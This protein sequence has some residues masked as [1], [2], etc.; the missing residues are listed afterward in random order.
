MRSSQ[1]RPYKECA[2]R[3]PSPFT[4]RIGNLRAGVKLVATNKSSKAGAVS[5]FYFYVRLIVT[6]TDDCLV[7]LR[8]QL[9][10]RFQAIVAIY[11]VGS[12]S[13]VLDKAP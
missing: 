11:V 2:L 7:I 10:I 1:T 9:V 12:S 6:T 4:T 5:P 13:H 3:T 8:L